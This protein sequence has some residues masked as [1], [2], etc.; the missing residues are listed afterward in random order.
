MVSRANGIE[1]L[2][3]YTGGWAPGM[4][5]PK[6]HSPGVFCPDSKAQ[7]RSLVSANSAS[8]GCLSVTV[9]RSQGHELAAKGIPADRSKPTDA[10]G[11]DR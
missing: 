3:A 7:P 9:F 11:G 8:S 2:I 10:G 1:Q 6:Q 4:A 5:T